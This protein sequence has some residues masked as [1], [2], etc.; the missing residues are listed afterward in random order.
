MNN[1]TENG[2]KKFT[3]ALKGYAVNEVDAYIEEVLIEQRQLNE[4]KNELKNKVNEYIAQEKFLHAA[5]IT[6]EQTASNIKSAAQKEAHEIISKAHDKADE[7]VNMAI[8]ETDDYKDDIYKVFY[9]YEHE[10]RIIIENFYKQARNHMDQLE[11]EFTEEVEKTILKY[12]GEF[13]KVLP[14]QLHS[15]KNEIIK[16]DSILEKWTDKEEAVFVGKKIKMDLVN[17]NGTVILGKDTTITPKI[18]ESVIEKGLYGE[19]ITV[20]NEEFEGEYIG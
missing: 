5:L 4:E 15:K 18:I 13:K 11:R 17:A 12:D 8:S 19:L 20:M 7:I 3:K 16:K 14:L 9:G 2:M 10:L 1:C 6:A